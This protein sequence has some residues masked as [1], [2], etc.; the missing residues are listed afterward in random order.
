M[1]ETLD[2]PVVEHTVNKEVV[3]HLLSQQSFESQGAICE[4]LNDMGYTGVNQSRISRW[5]GQLGVVKSTNGIG[6]RVYCVTSET[7]PVKVDS[8]VS[9]QIEFV[10]H[11]QAMVVVKTNPASA[12]LVARLVDTD[13]HPEILGTVGG[14][15]TVLIIPRDT[16]DI[17]VCENV[18]RKRLG[19]KEI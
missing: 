10:T 4:A 11:N 16:D 15:D 9:S 6:R 5:L 12:Q 18:V 3:K 13:P 8:A 19:L 2:L 1:S 17:I 7:A 14:N